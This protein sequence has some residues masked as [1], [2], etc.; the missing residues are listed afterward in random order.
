VTTFPVSM[1]LRALPSYPS[2]I[3][4]GDGISATTENGHVTIDLAHGDFGLISSVPTS[5]TN[6]ILTYDTA[7]GEYANIPSSLLG[8]AVSG[9]GDAPSDATLYGRKS[10][11]WVHVAI[12]DVPG[13][14]TALDTKA[15]LASPALTGNPT[16]PT[17]TPGDNDTS[18]ATTGFVRTAIAAIP[19]GSSLVYDYETRPLAAAAT[20]PAAIHMVRLGG[21]I[22]VG[23]GGALYT[24]VGSAPSHSA[25][26]Q[27]A[28]GG[29]WEIAPEYTVD[30]RQFGAISSDN[31]ANRATN[32]AAINDMLTYAAA[33]NL[34]CGIFGLFP[35]TKVLVPGNSRIFAGGVL[36]GDTTN[37]YSAVVEIVDAVDVVITGNLTV[38]ASYNTGYAC[39][40]KI[41]GNASLVGYVDIHGISIAGAQVGW[42]IGDLTK[43]DSTVSEITIAG[44]Y[45]YGTPTAL[46]AIGT[47]TFANF[48]GYKLQS[49]QGAGTGAWLSLPLKAVIVIGAGVIQTGGELLEVLDATGCGVELRPINSATYPKSYGTYKATGVVIEAAGYLGLAANPASVTPVAATRGGFEFGSGCVG[50]MMGNTVPIIST[51]A[52]F[53]GSII[54]GPNRFYSSVVRTP[55]TISC[56]GNADIYCDDAAFGLNFP[57]TL[58]GIT[59]GIVHFSHRHI[60]HAFNLVGQAL[61]ASSA[62]ALKFQALDNSGDKA[63]FASGYSTTTGVFTVPVGGLK[64]VLVSATFGLAA[65]TNGQLIVMVNGASRQGSYVNV[66]GN[67]MASL[68]PLNAGDTISVSLMNLTGATP[69]GSNAWDTLSI[70]AAR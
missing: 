15:P 70:Y 1:R 29:W 53:T 18:I 17:P 6:S 41:W 47:Q 5:P 60:L 26:F 36:L 66:Y 34:P 39:G 9:I 8:G 30:A 56:A 48:S 11:S 46:L 43:P 33:R 2:R 67:T 22:N 32:T 3:I 28:D 12:A 58:T 14:Q 27:S 7:T 68:G 55:Q 4:G 20:I 61:A 31:V 45:T 35:V 23:E 57:S 21:C 69:A 62:T 52:D 25:R 13:L 44:G 38:S 10:A 19:P 51:A 42:Q 63:H 59:G 37:S 24:R 65:V 50:I 40:V 54:C 49:A 16:A 64:E